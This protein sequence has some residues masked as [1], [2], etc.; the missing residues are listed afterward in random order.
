[1]SFVNS[2]SLCSKRRYVANKEMNDSEEVK[3]GSDYDY[4][5]WYFT[6]L[7]SLP[8]IHKYV[9]AIVNHAPSFGETKL[10]DHVHQF[11]LQLVD[12]WQRAFGRDV[13]LVTI[14]AIKKG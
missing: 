12:L 3:E 8:T 6:L 13:V 4:I 10:K 11:T 9:Q 7:E 1:M 5:D 2:V 14:V